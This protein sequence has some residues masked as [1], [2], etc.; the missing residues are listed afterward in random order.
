MLY[1]HST[2]L[3]TAVRYLL[4]ERQHSQPTGCSHCLDTAWIDEMDTWGQLEALRKLLC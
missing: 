1:R 4:E 2:K 3:S